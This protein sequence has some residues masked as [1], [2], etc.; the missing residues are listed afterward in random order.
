[1][2]VRHCL[3]TLAA[4]VQIAAMVTPAVAIDSPAVRIK[5]IATVAGTTGEKLM[6]YGLVVGLEGTGDS[7]SSAMTAQALANMLELFDLKTDAAS[8]TTENIAAVIVTATLPAAAHEGDRFD[9]SAASIGDATSLYGAVLLPT[10]LRGDSEEIYAIAQGSVSI[11]GINA[12]AGGQKVQKNHPVAGR[13]VNGGTVLRSV[14]SR[15]STQRVHF[16]L[17]QPDFTTALRLS[18]AINEFV[19]TDCAI[20]LA[21]ESV[22][23]TVPEKDQ[24][25]IVSFIASIE[26]LPVVGD[27]PARVV[28]NERTGTVIIGGDVRILPVAIAHGA[29]T[30]T[31]T[32]R[33]DV[34]QPP[35]FSGS[36]TV[37]KTQSANAGRRPKPS[38]VTAATTQQPDTGADAPADTAGADTGVASA[39]KAPA[40]DAKKTE[41][42]PQAPA[43]NNPALDLPG[44][45]TVVTPRTELTVDEEDSSL[46]QIQPQTQLRE[47]VEALNSLGVKPRDLMAILQ[48]LKEANALQAELVLM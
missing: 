27:T 36:T 28:I 21:A 31:I 20:A 23:V 22:E 6:G 25:D 17:R 42:R 5:D 10:P 19:G 39:Q 14:E 47:L 4:V 11:G 40:A 9:V 16:T 26:G 24:E 38:E 46:V 29:L 33:Y 3:L 18:Q 43:R 1:M 32:R 37:L 44:A 30:I 8:L 45:R 41:S 48:A 35:P 12:Q 7:N 34:S 15:L 2:S 13:I